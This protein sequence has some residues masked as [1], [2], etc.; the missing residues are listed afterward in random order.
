MRR[1]FVILAFACLSMCAPVRGYSVLTHEAII[2]A[3]WSKDLRP[4]LERRFPGLSAEQ[5]RTAHAYA[6]GGAIVQDMGYY[7]FGSRFFSD[8]VHYTRS[9]DFILALLREAQDPNEYAF[10]LG[11][12]AHYAADNLG[13]PIAV[14]RTVAME[15]PKLARKY[16]KEVTYEDDRGAHLKAEFGFDVI[17]VARG[18]YASDSYHDF[19]GFQVARPVL[20]RAFEDTY[21]LP[22]S[23]LFGDMDLALGTFRYA[24]S[25]AIPEMTKTAWA[26]KKDEIQSLQ[27][28]MTKRKFVYRLSQATYRREWTRKYRRPGPGARFLAWLFNLI[29]K[30]GPLQALAFKV[31][32]PAG[33][34]LFLTSLKDTL[35]RYH[36]LL[37]VVEQG[38]LQLPNENF[39]TGVPTRWGEYRLADQAYSKLLER[40]DGEPAKVNDALR[41]NI[42]SFYAGTDGPS[43]EKARTVLAAL[44]SR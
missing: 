19:V 6:Y 16:G 25:R 43:S 14:N 37:M 13:H 35:E 29:P 11:A 42:L 17:Q 31:P 32:P 30:V 33:E 8:L 15:Y 24:V 41:T 36:G 4:M 2:D 28:S 23:S 27:S 1:R 12:L 38:Q 10:A 5:L 21:S 20:E 7:P 44:R 39:D 34:N 3:S 22:L 26:T 18:L 9:G 40:F